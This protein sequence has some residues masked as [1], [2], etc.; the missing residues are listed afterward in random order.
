MAELFQLWLAYCDI[1]YAY[2]ITVVIIVNARILN[3]NFVP[4]FRCHQHQQQAVWPL[5]SADTVYPR[6]SLTL[7]FD[8]STLKQ[9]CESRLR[10]GTFLPN[11]GMLGLWVL[12]LCAVYVTDG[13]TDWRTDRRTNKSNAYCPLAYGRGGGILIFGRPVIG[14]CYK[15][16]A[17]RHIFRNATVL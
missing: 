6:P 16:I 15:F 9:V 2:Q 11:L 13:Q 14:M 12:E 3:L 8:R 4:V 5:G 17:A 7:T 10:W 1:E